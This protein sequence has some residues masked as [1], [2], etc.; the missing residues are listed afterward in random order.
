MNQRDRI[1]QDS[2]QSDP[3]DKMNMLCLEGGKQGKKIKDLYDDLTRGI[4]LYDKKCTRV[5]NFDT[6]IDE[7]YFDYNGKNSISLADK[8]IN[9]DDD[10]LMNGGPVYN[11]ISGYSMT[12][13]QNMPLERL[14][15]K[16]PK[17]L[18]IIQ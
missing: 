17:D 11:D 16:R 10:H 9:Y 14:Y 2:H 12:N 7:G 8:P 6:M 1:M 13:S 3:V 18:R 5:P 15:G 4:N